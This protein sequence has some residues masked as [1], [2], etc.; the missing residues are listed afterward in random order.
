MLRIFSSCFVEKNISNGFLVIDNIITDV[1]AL[2]RVHSNIQTVFYELLS[3][4]FR[5]ILQPLIINVRRQ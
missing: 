3:N 1:A 5:K 4:Q 2:L